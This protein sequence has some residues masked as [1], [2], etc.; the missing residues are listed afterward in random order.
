MEGLF[1]VTKE[2]DV[3]A[4]IAKIIDSEELT[5]TIGA[6]LVLG[7]TITPPDS[8]IKTATYIIKK[9]E[10]DGFRAS[11][12]YNQDYSPPILK[13]DVQTDDHIKKQVYQLIIDI[14]GVNDKNT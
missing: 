11:I 4:S 6:K 12:W 10:G 9:K 2:F 3:A 5:K 13:V 8:R 14:L 1:K 7:D